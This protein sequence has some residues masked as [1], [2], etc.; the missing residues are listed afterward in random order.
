MVFAQYGAAN[1]AR[2]GHQNPAGTHLACAVE[3]VEAS[4]G[5]GRSEVV[6]VGDTSQHPG[7]IGCGGRI[8]ALGARALDD[9]WQAP[10]GGFD[11]CGDCRPFILSRRATQVGRHKLLC[12]TNT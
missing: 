3:V 8:G 2:P 4:L 1:G 10:R 9:Q 6:H 12:I 11:E 7:R 5:F